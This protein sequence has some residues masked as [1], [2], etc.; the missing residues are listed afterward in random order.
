MRPVQFFGIFSSVLIAIALLQAALSPCL[1]PRT[2]YLVNRIRTYRPQYWEIYKYK[3]VI[4][5]STLFMLVD[6]LGGVFSD[7]S[8]AF[9]EKFDVVAGVTYSL[10]VVRPALIQMS[11]QD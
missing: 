2:D 3:E 8:L 4:G 6:M 11:S 9:K 10:V 5:I 1:F 7:L